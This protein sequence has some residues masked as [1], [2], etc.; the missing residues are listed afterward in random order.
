MV[1]VTPRY[2]EPAERF[3]QRFKRTCS[4][5]GLFREIKRRRFYEKP[6]ERRRREANESERRIRKAERRRARLSRSRNRRARPAE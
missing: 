3:L 1:K 5:S 4:K 6:S 2:N